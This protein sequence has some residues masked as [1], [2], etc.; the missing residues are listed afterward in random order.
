MLL[1]YTWTVYFDLIHISSPS[2]FP[3][4]ILAGKKEGG[5]VKKK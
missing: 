4:P 5:G 2:P 3:L 1:L